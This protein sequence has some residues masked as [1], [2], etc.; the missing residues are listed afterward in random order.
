VVGSDDYVYQVQNGNYSGRK[1]DFKAS[2]IT[3]TEQTNTIW[4]IELGTGIPHKYLG[5]GVWESFRGIL[6]NISVDRDG[7]LWGTNANTN[8]YRNTCFN[9]NFK[10]TKIKLR[11]NV[12]LY[13]NPATHRVHIDVP[14]YNGKQIHAV[15]TNIL[16]QKVLTKSFSNTK[17]RSMSIDIS[18]LE[19][20]LYILRIELDKQQSIT[21]QLMVN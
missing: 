20:G 2:D 11:S 15:L 10:S 3:V 8:I 1:G 18:T 21:K 9:S 13:P 6:T 14:S 12:I 4:A 7:T 16:G 17:N 19:K 5:N